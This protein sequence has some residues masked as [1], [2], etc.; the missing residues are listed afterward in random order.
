MSEYDVIIV[1]GGPAGLAGA[2]YTAR[3]NLKTVV[4]DRGPL[5]GQLL[6]TELV[7]DYPGFESVLGSD[8]ALKM[9]DH[10]PKFGVA[11]LHPAPAQR[12]ARAADPGPARPG[13]LEDRVHLRRPRQGDRGGREGP[14]RAL[15][16]ARR[17]ERAAR[18]RRIHLHRV[19]AQLIAVEDPR[20]P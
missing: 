16:A 20:R 15:R 13:E 4:L 9:G 12:A 3:M 1:G 19:H 14:G 18:R 17:N 10:A 7:E 5:G 11:G 2:L 6:N 8:L